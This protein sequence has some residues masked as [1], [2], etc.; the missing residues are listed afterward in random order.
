MKITSLMKFLVVLTITFLATQAIAQEVMDTGPTWK[1]I[2]LLPLI[3]TLATIITGLFTWLGRKIGAANDAA[4]NKANAEAAFIRLGAV[5]FAMAGDLWTILSN[6]F[7]VR[8]A[9]GTFDKADRDAFKE[10]INR[11]IE[12]YTSREELEK[13]AAATGLPLPGVIAWIAEWVIDRLTKAN[14]PD[15]ME[16]PSMYAPRVQGTLADP[17][18]QGG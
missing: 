4:K 7:Q 13:L 12:K 18:A 17:S 14:D 9:D 16:V 2:P 1:G 10:I 5:A 11:Q 3:T 6:E 15:I 8:I